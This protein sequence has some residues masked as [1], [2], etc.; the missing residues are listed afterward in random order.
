MLEKANSVV[1]ICVAFE[2]RTSTVRRTARNVGYNLT[3]S[4]G[5][6]PMAQFDVA[7]ALLVVDTDHYPH[8]GVHA[9]GND[10]RGFA[11]AKEAIKNP[12]FFAL[13][14]VAKYTGKSLRVTYEESRPDDP[15]IRRVN[16]VQ[17]LE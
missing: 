1:T 10:P 7:P 3:F 14:A 13:A 2:L 12:A 8:F 4:Y 6:V 17:V 5:G 11:F 16:E 9:K 15:S